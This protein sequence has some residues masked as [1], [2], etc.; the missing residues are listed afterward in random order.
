MKSCSLS[1]SSGTHYLQ[2]NI[3]QR[4]FEIIR[5]TLNKS[6][7]YLHQQRS[8]ALKYAKNALAA[9]GPSRTPLGELPHTL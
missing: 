7:F 6:N 2:N 1:V 9:G 3:V 4:I 5:F 8:V